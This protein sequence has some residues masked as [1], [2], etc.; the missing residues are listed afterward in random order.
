M[1]D[2]RNPWDDSS[3]R[4]KKPDNNDDL[5]E[6]IRKSQEKIVDFLQA[7]KKPSGS[8]GNSNFSGSNFSLPSNKIIIIALLVVL[9]S[10]L[11]TGFY[12]VQPDEEGVVLRLG[13]YNRTSIPGLNY[14]FPSPIETIVKVST[15]RINR[16]IIGF[17][18]NSPQ[19][20]GTSRL[21]GS[22]PNDVADQ[23]IENRPEESQML[24][25]DENIVDINFDVQWKVKDAKNFLFN[26]RDLPNENTVKS[27]AES[28]IREVI[29]IHKISDALAQERF[30]IEQ[31]AKQLLQEMLNNYK[32]GVHIERLQLLRVQPPL[33]VIDS[34]RDVQSAKADKEKLINEALA[35][36]NSMLPRARG[37]AEKFLQDA[38]GYKQQ[39]IASAQGESSRFN[40]I[41][42]EYQKAKDVTRKRMY[43]ETMEEILSGMDKIIM[44]GKASGGTVPYLPLN[45]LLKNNNNSEK[46]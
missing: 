33:E 46:K 14:K 43:L 3:N 5:D 39:V 36:R 24:T 41:Y 8:G 29:G 17:R 38:E 6:I 44:D 19:N 4:N 22:K 40:S 28:A 26:L 32:M 35:Y 1:S 37:E 20:Y 45:E 27:C 42:N 10:W 34:Y 13:K 12:T 11:S 2:F 16:E 25:G 21:F 31:K 23:N 30:Q 7:K 18:S 15:T 9:L